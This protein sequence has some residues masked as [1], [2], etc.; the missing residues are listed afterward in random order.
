V[1]RVTVLAA[2]AL[3]WLRHLENGLLTALVLL[4]VVLAGAQ[5]VLRDLFHTG[6]SFADPL[7]RQL[8]LWTGM[9]G[10]LAAVRDDKHIALDVLQRFLGPAAQKIARV[11]TLGFAALACALIAYY[12][13]TMVQNDYDGASPSPLA[14]VPA[15]MAELILPLGFGLMALRFALRAFAPPAHAHVL[16]HDPG[17]ATA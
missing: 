17:K 9:L 14:G 3:R 12:S 11:L 7:M 2:R 4:L 16:L 6:L 8:V 1:N 13:Y 15:W 10:A 5:I